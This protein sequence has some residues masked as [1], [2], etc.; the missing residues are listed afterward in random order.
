MCVIKIV[1]LNDV[2][3]KIVGKEVHYLV[4][5]EGYNLSHPDVIKFDNL[6]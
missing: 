4:F 2:C 6:S 1:F 3:L 5:V